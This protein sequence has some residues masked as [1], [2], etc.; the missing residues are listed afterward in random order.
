MPVEA[1]PLLR[2]DV[3]RSHVSAF[4]LPPRVA[5]CRPKLQHWAK[6]LSTGRADSG[7]RYT[8]S[9]EKHV[10]VDGKFADAVLGEFSHDPL[11]MPKY[12]VAIEGKGPRDPPAYRST[13]RLKQT[14]CESASK[15]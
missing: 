12:I 6:L 15:Y 4:D 7:S 8:F 11:A 13:V 5:D 10:Q 14:C 9:R 1:K 2:P 3:L